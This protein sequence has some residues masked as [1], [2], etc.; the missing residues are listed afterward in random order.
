[1]NKN[2]KLILIWIKENG[3]DWGREEAKNNLK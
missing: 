1:M 2:N 3:A